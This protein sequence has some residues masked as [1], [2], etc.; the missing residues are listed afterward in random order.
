MITVI[1]KNLSANKEL[2]SLPILSAPSV[3]LMTCALAN[4]IEI[5]EII[6]NLDKHYYCVEY[7]RN[8]KPGWQTLIKVSDRVYPDVWWSHHELMRTYH[9]LINDSSASDIHV[10][11][12]HYIN[13]NDLVKEELNMPDL[14]E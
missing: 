10:Y 5:E 4:E 8:S 3:H 14:N 11:L 13:G 12:T 1:A 7:K 6:K 2:C 9:Q